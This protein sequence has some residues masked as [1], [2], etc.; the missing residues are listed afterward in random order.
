MKA[1]AQSWTTRVQLQ[2]LKWDR[3]PPLAQTN[4]EK[5][6]AGHWGQGKED[7][8]VPHYNRCLASITI[9]RADRPGVDKRQGNVRGLEI[10]PGGAPTLSSF[11]T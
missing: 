3:L 6:D 9:S 8:D 2:Y 7:E 10:L 5:T 1:R 4:G 11:L